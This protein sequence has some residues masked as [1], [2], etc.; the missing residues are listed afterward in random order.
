VGSRRLAAWSMARPFYCVYRGRI[1]DWSPV[2]G[3]LLTVCKIHN[4]RLILKGNKSNMSNGHEK[5]G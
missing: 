1:T 4:F 5:E 2:W 3:V